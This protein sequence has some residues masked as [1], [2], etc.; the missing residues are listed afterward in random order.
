[1]A[2]FIRELVGTLLGGEKGAQAGVSGGCGGAE[3]ALGVCA[4]E[5]VDAGRAKK[6]FQGAELNLRLPPEGERVE[7][8]VK[9]GVVG[10]LPA[11]E[12]ER[13]AGLMRQGV[14]LGC[15]V[16]L[17]DGPDAVRVRLSVL[18]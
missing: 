7:A 9:A 11:G 1:M 6:L 13:V 10:L 8:V 12:C 18:M 17:L 5:G 15:R 3:V 14:R 16:V 2:G 4:L